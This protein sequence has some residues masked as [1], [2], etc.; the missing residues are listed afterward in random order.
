MRTWVLTTVL[1]SNILFSAATLLGDD[2]LS[3]GRQAFLQKWMDSSGISSS[4]DIVRIG[5]GPHP[6]SE[7]SKK[8]QQVLHLELLFKG[9]SSGR[10]EESVRFQQVLAAYQEKHGVT[11]P[12]K[13][14]Y[15]F[16]QTFAV[17]R[18]NASV[19]FSVLD[20]Q[21]SVFVSPKSAELTVREPESRGDPRH[22]SV[23]IPVAVPKEQFRA[24]SAGSPDESARQV[25][26]TIEGILESYFQ[27]ANQR[28]GLPKP[29]IT[30]VR[31]DGYLGLK[32]GSVKGLVTDRYWEWVSINIE[33]SRDPSE[34]VPQKPQWRI[35]CYVA[36]KYASS[37]NE[38]S[39]T[40]ADDDYP[41][42]VNNLRDKLIDQIQ[43]KLEKRNHD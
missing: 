27:E 17:G 35:G 21:Y 14:F 41:S 11:L 37:P 33:I 25:S 38:K 36:V 9:G 34:V 30:P 24:R 10:A 19:D 18:R 28:K 31:E 40:D 32:V 42:Q 8:G 12:E 43:Q 13:I 39:K 15:E 22:F 4:F 7:L 23:A 26:D 16:I 5:S 3:T 1:C 6:D 29:D 2:E 20:D